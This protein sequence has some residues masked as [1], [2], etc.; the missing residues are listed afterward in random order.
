M[1]FEL[2]TS[3]MHIRVFFWTLR[4]DRKF[5]FLFQLLI[6][7]CVSKHSW[8][9]M[10]DGD[11]RYTSIKAYLYSVSNCRFFLRDS[12]FHSIS[13]DSNIGFT[14]ECCIDN[15]CQWLWFTDE[16]DVSSTE[17]NNKIRGKRRRCIEKHSKR[18]VFLVAL[19]YPVPP[20]NFL[21]K[22]SYVLTNQNKLI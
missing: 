11:N 12:L 18:W 13:I 5:V 17:K 10:T 7:V 4:S 20:V 16:C 2:L 15:S 9:I 3:C 6:K 14:T 8:N 21:I 1:G 22:F 19:A